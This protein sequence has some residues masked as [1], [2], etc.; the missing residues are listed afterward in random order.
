MKIFLKEL[1]L[2]NFKGIR[3]KTINFSQRT[4]IS[5]RNKLG[6][7][8]IFDAFLWLFFGKDS[9]DRKDFEIKTLDA[10]NKHFHKLDHEVSA[11]I[12]VD[13]D[14]VTIRR[15][16]KEN[17]VKKS[18]EATTTFKGHTTSYFWDEV[19]LKLE[20]YQ[21]KIASI[22]KEETFKLLTNA[23]YFNMQK[24][25]K[26]RG[27]LE[28]IGGQLSD[29]ELLQQMINEGDT[30]YQ[31]LFDALTGTK[32]VDD[33][34][35]TIGAKKKKIKDELELIPSRIDEANRSLPEPVDYDLITGYLTTATTH[36]EGVENQL[37]DKTQA[38]KEHQ[39]LISG[40]LTEMQ[41]AKLQR[42]QLEFN[43]G[44]STKDLKH[45]RQQTINDKQA[46]LNAL[47]SEIN[48]LTIEYGNDE[49]RLIS[50]KIK[51]ENV[52]QE[53]ITVDAKTLIFKDGEFS[54]PACHRAYE[55]T[56]IETKQKQLTQNFNADKSTQLND[57]TARGTAIATEI[58]TLE[59][60]L[61]NTK[62]TGIAKRA[63]QQTLQEAINI[64]TEENTRLNADEQNQI[65]A[66][67]K[68]DTNI[69][70][71]NK[72][73]TI[74]NS[75]INAPAPENIDADLLQQKNGLSSQINTY[76]KQ[77]SS[78]QYRE[79]ISARII[80]LTNQEKTMATELADL[81]GIEHSILQ[82]SKGKMNAL[83]TRINQRFTMVKFKL[84]EE[85]IN[86]TS[87][88]CCETLISGVPYSDANTASKINAG[89]D[90]INTLSD[91]Y[92]VYAPVFIDNAESVNELIHT[93]SQMVALIVSLDEQLIISQID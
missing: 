47:T 7:T 87:I 48:R 44:N 14:T 71:L 10:D 92:N 21:A 36:L 50:L 18:G 59:I 51:K 37:M 85:Q 25:E 88:P 54:C 20:E 8:T 28:E 30:T 78:K 4:N 39:N 31:A 42:Q 13:N 19:P 76:K 55:T 63:E 56:D 77:L 86:G 80:E 33:Y 79:Q 52:T 12:M 66:A 74:L 27:I 60:K 83:E 5:G 23:N 90:I 89:L 22:L 34:Q 24:W 35:R 46:Q 41:N 81:E 67:I 43:I 70:A 16:L 82:F 45:S 58:S 68:N 73:I 29:K 1:T 9:T 32:T 64:L 62:A 17:W 72:K 65:I 57:I 38:Q 93:N 15:S 2:T 3:A 40:K 75:E 26:R 49:N 6:K 53:W 11:V 61:S 69:I 84:F 91:H